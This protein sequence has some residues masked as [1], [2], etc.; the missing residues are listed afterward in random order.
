MNEVAKKKLEDL[1][2]LEAPHARAATRKPFSLAPVRPGHPG[3]VH[4]LAK[5]QSRRRPGG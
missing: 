3:S 1:K 2:T 5:R 4:R